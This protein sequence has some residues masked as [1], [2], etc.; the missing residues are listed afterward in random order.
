M[1]FLKEVVI[2]AVR[3]PKTEK[4]LYAMDVLGVACMTEEGS[5]R[6]ALKSGGVMNEREIAQQDV[7]EGMVDL[8]LTR[9]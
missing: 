2:R 3:T 4:L 5:W 6:D 8:S 7:R 1:E 9:R